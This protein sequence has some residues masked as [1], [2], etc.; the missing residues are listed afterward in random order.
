MQTYLVGG[1]VRDR[2]LDLPVLER[3]WVVVGA[4]AAELIALGYQQVGKDFPVF[5]HPQSKEEYALARTE[6]KVSEGHTGFTVHA[7]PGVTLEEDLIRRDLTI[8]AIAE[9]PDGRLIDPYGGLKDIQERRLQHISAAFSEDPLR[10]LRVARF[11]T[12]L[13]PLGFTISASTSALMS[14]IA[15]SGELSLLSKERVWQETR[16]ALSCP[17]AHVYFQVLLDHDALSQLAAALA[18]G[19]ENQRHKLTLLPQLAD[20]EMRFSASVLLACQQ[21][22]GFD[23]ARGE[24]I[25]S[26]FAT[27][28]ALQQETQ[29][30]LKHWS[31]CEQFF[32]QTAAENLRLLAALD[33]FR[34]NDRC[35]HIL[36]SMCC[37]AAL[38]TATEATNALQERLR[39]ICKIAYDIS[40][41][42]LPAAEQQRLQGREIG[43]ALE[44]A[45]CAALEQGMKQAK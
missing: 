43:L 14:V 12:K 42:R 27:P 24:A 31:A 37:I 6:R 8:N 18:L 40:L 1:A 25:L 2:L 13:K 39:A 3:D 21:T 26:C 32:S 11:A 44:K 29:L 34:R 17:Q 7:A 4:T 9:D 35:L 28:K 30:M 23:L 16:K 5:L 38:L 45:R 41:V 20:A 15:E 19:L 33:V 36:E 22:Q 10:V